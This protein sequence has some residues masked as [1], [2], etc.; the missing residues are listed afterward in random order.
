MADRQSLK[1]QRE[2]LRTIQ[3]VRSAMQHAA[4]H[5]LLRS[6]R[7]AFEADALAE[8]AHAACERAAETWQG[9]LSARHPDPRLVQALAVG[10]VSKDND[11]QCAATDAQAAN[12]QYKRDEQLWALARAAETG[13]VRATQDAT[14]RLSLA[15]EE[16]SAALNEDLV[17]QRRRWAQ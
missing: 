7:S 14:R 1:V 5:A 17:L 8:N 4:H 10:V 15:R 2:R 6:Q 3:S 16:H 13:A 9:V 11:R 12:D